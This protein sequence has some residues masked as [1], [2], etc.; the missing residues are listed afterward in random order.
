MWYELEKPAALFWSHC[1]TPIL[2]T[3]LMDMKN[4]KEQNPILNLSILSVVRHDDTSG[5]FVL[6]N[7]FDTEFEDA[8]GIRKRIPPSNTSRDAIQAA[9][10]NTM[11]ATGA[12][13]RILFYFAGH[14]VQEVNSEEPS[15]H[16]SKKFT[17]AIVAGDGHPIFGWADVKLL[18]DER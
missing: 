1:L 2:A 10:Q 4:L 15:Q 11:Q 17:Q 7:D 3:E 5:R 8:A 16:S 9:I 12:D 13:S 6:L 14:G 18:S